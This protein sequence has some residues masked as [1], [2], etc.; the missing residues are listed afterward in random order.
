MGDIATWTTTKLAC[1]SLAWVGVVLLA[2]I[3]SLALW[4]F[5]EFLRDR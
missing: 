2:T 1:A 3:L 5:S 4:S